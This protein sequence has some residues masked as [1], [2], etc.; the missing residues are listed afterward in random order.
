MKQKQLI[1][2]LVLV[3]ALG[4]VGYVLRRNQQDAFIKGGGPSVD[5]KLFGDLPVND[6]AQISIKHATDELNLAKKDDLWRVRERSDYP[7]NFADANRGTS[8]R[9]FL[10]KAKDVKIVQVET[11]GPT[12]L[13]RLQ[14]APG[15]G[16]NSPVIVDLRDKDGKLIKSFSLGKKHTRKS[17]RPSPFGEMGDE[18]GIMCDV[19]PTK[20]AREAFVVSLTHLR[21][22]PNHPLAHDIRAYQRERVRRIEQSNR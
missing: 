12:H 19:T 10:T 2:L 16:S 17:D 9:D 4:V 11:V 3:V 7:A 22:A 13:G 8:I 15:E 21:I 6:V 5:K 18:G 20:A 14:L 1:I